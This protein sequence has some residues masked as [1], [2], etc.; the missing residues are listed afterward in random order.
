MATAS[1]HT[2]LKWAVLVTKRQGLNRDLPPGKEK[3]MWVPTSATLIYGKQDAVLVDA[4]LTV[5]QADGVLAWV[6]ASGQNLTTIYITRGHGDHFFGI[7]ALLNRFPNAKAV[8][9]SNVLKVMRRQ[10]SPEYL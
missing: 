4:F 10:A 1:V 7:G 5:G 3:W 6:A 2:P 9:T 8:A